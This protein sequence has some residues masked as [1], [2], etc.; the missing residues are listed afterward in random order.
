MI[1]KVNKVTNPLTIIAIFSALAEIAGTVA[2]PLVSNELQNYFIWYVMGL[3]VLLVI[4][5]FITLNFNH[6]VLYSPSDFINEEN[7]MQL[8]IKRERINENYNEMT[9]QLQEIQ[10]RIT[11]VTSIK[12]STNEIQEIVKKVD[13]ISA[14]VRENQN[15]TN[16][17]LI[18]K[19]PKIVITKPEALERNIERYISTHESFSERDLGRF[20][21]IPSIE[22]KRILNGYVLSNRLKSEKINNKTTYR[23][24]EF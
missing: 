6:K 24:K 12:N 20:L 11:N 21:G 3:P 14:I 23:V 17:I 19:Q 13:E 2:L 22:T 4:C 10:E 1:E 16:D 8:S 15:E 9:D 18:N 5:F 7:F